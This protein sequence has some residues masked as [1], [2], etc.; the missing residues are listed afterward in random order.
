MTADMSNV[1]L[2]D[3][4]RFDTGAGSSVR[5]KPTQF[6]RVFDADLTR[7]IG[8][9]FDAVW[10]DVVKDLRYSPAELEFARGYL[11]ER[12]IDLAK[13]GEADPARLREEG[14]ALFHLVHAAQAGVVKAGTSS[15]AAALSSQGAP[16]D[17]RP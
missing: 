8:D 16:G 12:I 5:R 15:G 2:A 3:T 10:A 1:V 13:N 4:S 11:A 17:N 6:T 9:A 7:I 14:R